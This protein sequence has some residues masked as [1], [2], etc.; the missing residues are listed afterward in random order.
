MRRVSIAGLMVVVS[1]CGVAAA[2]LARPTDLWAGVMLLVTLALLGFSLLAVLNRR[3]GQRAFWQGFAIFGWGYLILTLGPWF[4][5]FVG[6]G[7]ATHQALDALYRKIHP[8][9]DE[10]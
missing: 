9:P 4:K 7:L 2:A 8:G 10:S 5:D 3:E 6:P 1:V